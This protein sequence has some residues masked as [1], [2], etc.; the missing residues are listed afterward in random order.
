MKNFTKMFLATCLLT[1][2]AFSLNAQSVGINATGDAPNG[3]AMLDVSSTSKGFLPPRMTT[4]QRNA[5]PSLV[6]GLVIYNTDE[7]TLN[8]CN[9]TSWG[10]INPF[11]CGNSFSDP[12]DNKAYTSV[13]I[14]TQ[15]WMAKNLAYLPSVVGSG[16]SST[17]LP[18][19]YVYEYNGTVVADAKATANYQTYGV[20]YNWPSSLTAC[21][22]G[23]H[24]PTDAEWSSLTTY[25]AGES[26]GDKLKEA[27]TTHWSSWSYPNSGATNEIGYTALPAGY[28]YYGDWSGIGSRGYWWSS[29]ELEENTIFVW[30][31]D[32]H[33][34][35]GGVYV[36]NYTKE[37]GL[38]VRCL[39]DF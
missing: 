2:F 32:M 23:W 14:G 21:P 28:R 31:R 8:I 30:S 16:S 15:C 4:D 34:D 36:R 37:Y 7:Q 29:T 24:L 19:Y 6:A 20:L 25:L 3:S 12:R 9:G 18:L 26:D 38:S 27:G 5:I 35:F 17:T 11:V 13:Q 1:V 39:Q 22:T 10:L 33:N